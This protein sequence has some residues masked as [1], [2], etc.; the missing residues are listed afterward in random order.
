MN[1]KLIFLI[2]ILLLCFQYGNSQSTTSIIVDIEKIDNNVYSAALFNKGDSVLCLLLSPF[3]SMK[4][5]S[6]PISLVPYNEKG[7]KTIYN[8]FYS[9]EYSMIDGAIGAYQGVCIL[10]YQAVIL[11]FEIE[12]TEKSKKLRIDYF[13]KEDYCHSK[14]KKEIKK[15]GWYNRY[16]LRK[17][18]VEF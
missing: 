11:N 16:N 4:N 3:Y 2:G 10:P 17:Q 6:I 12:P 13:L 1:R 7:E 5:D 18:Y 9:K 14:F 15:R 8:I